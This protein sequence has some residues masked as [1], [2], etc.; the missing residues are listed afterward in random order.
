MQVIYFIMT[1]VVGGMLVLVSSVSPS[2]SG[3]SAFELARRKKQGNNDAAYELKR[4][5][6]IAE[7]YSLRRMAVA[8]LL[9]LFVLLS[10]G[11]W[12]GLVGAVVS[13]L[14]ALLYGKVATM[15]GVHTI[16]MRL[17][18]ENEKSLLELIEQ[19]PK[20]MAMLRSVVWVEQR[21]ALGS[22]EELEHLVSESQGILRE[23]DKRRIVNSLQ[24]DQRT[25]EE[26]M[27]PRG[28]MS[29][30][31]KQDVVGP[32]TLNDLHQTGHS[33]FPVIDGDIDHVVG[34]LFTRNLIT[35][36]DKNT[37]T[38]GD[39]MDDHVYY[40]NADQ[41]LDHALT[42]FLKT[43]RHMFIVVNGY[44]E[45]AGV[46]TLEDVIEALLGY[47]IVDEFDQHDDLRAVAERMAHKNNN[48]PHATNV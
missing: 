33:R 26:V 23:Q 18:E 13:V 35:L 6:S 42:A 39:L 40:I 12:G 43:H 1:L 29:T 7:L 20:L 2:R 15:S 38:A 32:Y 22:R 3:V 28:V 16:A 24:F 21:Q 19:H 8:V 14:V 37:K 31:N 45:T 36:H 48:P 9:V 34:I 47:K 30:I 17:Y 10:V 46:I 25:V 5:A 44:R 27:T 41:T 4:E 11:A